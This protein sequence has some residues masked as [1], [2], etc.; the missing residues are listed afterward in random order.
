[1]PRLN[2]VRF[3]VGLLLGGY[4]GH[5]GSREVLRAIEYLL[6]AQLSDVLGTFQLALLRGVTALVIAAMTVVVVT[7]GVPARAEESARRAL[8]RRV[9]AV[10]FAATLTFAALT[11]I[12]LGTPNR[13]EW[14]P[15]WRSHAGDKRAVVPSNPS[16]VSSATL[17]ATIG[18]QT[19]ALLKYA[20]FRRAYLPLRRGDTITV[21]ALPGSTLTWLRHRDG[22]AWPDDYRP[23]ADWGEVIATS[24]IAGGDAR[25]TATTSAWY[26]I[27]FTPP[28]AADAES[29]VQ[30]ALTR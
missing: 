26:A 18:P 15:G 8:A 21:R 29:G 16:L 13:S 22:A 27:D 17:E 10:A 23:T 14:P 4:L 1:M 30:L 25:F 2:R 20:G 9:N 24:T 7:W 5:V 12:L 11:I 19:P 3:A 28:P 6:A